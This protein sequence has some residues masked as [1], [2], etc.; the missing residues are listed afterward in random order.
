MEIS[1]VFSTDKATV[2]I[3]INPH[4][5]DSIIYV[6]GQETVKHDAALKGFFKA[7]P[8]ALGIVQIMSGITI[9]SLGVF[10][11]INVE[12][13]NIVVI[14]GLTYWGSL[15]YIAAGSL[16][17]AAQNKRHLRLESI[18]RSS[19]IILLFTISQFIISI[20][21]SALACKATCNIQSTVVKVALNQLLLSGSLQSIHTKIYH[22]SDQPSTSPQ[23]ISFQTVQIMIGV[24]V[25]SLGIVYNANINR[26]VTISLAAGINYWGS[27]IYISAGSLSVAAQNKL[28]P[29]VV[30]I[31]N[32]LKSVKASLGMNVFSAT[33]ATIAILLMGLDFFNPLPP[34]H[35][36]YHYYGDDD[37]VISKGFVLGIIILLLVFSSLQFIISICIAAFACKATSNNNSTVVSVELNQVNDLVML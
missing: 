13:P 5:K 7:Q 19:G 33:T 35:C 32:V 23:L 9:F 17:V 15:I 6:D 25:F 4:A 26:M 21:V 3:Q 20:C 27:V 1:E 11:T 10:L 29:C 8:K 31:H 34:Y 28:H 37:C 2:V 22:K 30:C 18:L 24:M 36:S 14:S 16:S 12:F